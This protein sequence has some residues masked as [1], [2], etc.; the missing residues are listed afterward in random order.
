MSDR[1]SPRGGVLL[2]YE[3]W[4]E[5]LRKLAEGK[6]APEW[7]CHQF[8]SIRPDMSFRAKREA[9]RTAVRCFCKRSGK[10]HPAL[11]LMYSSAWRVIRGSR[12]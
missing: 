3:E 2:G 4:G 5:G 10:Y 7:V 1:S 9:Y 6:A 8:L 12:W 11:Y